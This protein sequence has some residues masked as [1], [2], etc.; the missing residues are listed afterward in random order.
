MSKYLIKEV[1]CNLTNGG[2]A[3]GPVFGNVV[4]S[5]QYEHDGVVKWFHAVEVE[6]F[7]NAFVRQDDIFDV[8]LKDDYD[9]DYV[10]DLEE[11]S[12]KEVAGIELT[13]EYDDIIS[14]L[15]DEDASDEDK[16]F[17]RYILAIVRSDWDVVEKLK[18]AAIGHYTDE[19][20]IPM[21]D[22]EENYLEDQEEYEEEYEED[23]E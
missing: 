7:L 13:G 21:S 4:V 18:K 1:K 17:L 8:L 22:L 14:A 16:S 11:T 5:I 20:D 23:D 9:A 6:G 19:L 15:Y 3:C 2:M 10:D 12:E